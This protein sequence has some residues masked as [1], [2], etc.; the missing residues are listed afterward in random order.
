MKQIYTKT[1]DKGMTGLRGGTRVPKDDMRIEVNGQ[2][3]HLNACLGM[4]RCMMDEEE[5]DR[6]LLYRV[7]QEL[8][9]VMSHIATPDDEVNPRP[10]HT[11]EITKLM[12]QAIDAISSPTGFVIPG[13]GG[14]LSARLHLARTVARTVERRLWTLHRLHPVDE[15][16]PVMFNRLS[17]YLFI[18]ALKYEKR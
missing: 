8:M 18:L 3:D 12:E 7:Q 16:I 4:V 1:G 17:D 14:M 10:L 5:T 6:L 15:S 13:D 2:I 9:T 11:E